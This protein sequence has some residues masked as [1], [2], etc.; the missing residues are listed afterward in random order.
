M[1]YLS[2][3]LGYSCS[4][5]HSKTAV[6]LMTYYQSPSYLKMFSPAA[7]FGHFEGNL[8]W[9]DAER[10]DKEDSI[11]RVIDL[12]TSDFFHSSLLQKFFQ[13]GAY[14]KMFVFYHQ[15]SRQVEISVFGNHCQFCFEQALSSSIVLNETEIGT[16]QWLELHPF[17]QN[18]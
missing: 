18:P 6:D 7:A 14:V 5:H 2:C 9:L 17:V 4:V 15:T 10:F 16:H 13:V 12:L 3:R 11:G 8:T 1:M